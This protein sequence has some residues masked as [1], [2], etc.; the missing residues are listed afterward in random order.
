VRGERDR[1]EEREREPLLPDRLEAV[2]RDP[3]PAGRA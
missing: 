3:R 2:R 1:L